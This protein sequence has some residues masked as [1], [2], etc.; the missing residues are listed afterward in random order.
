[1]FKTCFTLFFLYCTACFL[2]I[3]ETYARPSIA[4]EWMDYY[5]DSNSDDNIKKATGTTCQLCHASSDG[6]NSYNPYGWK[7]KGLGALDNPTKA[8]KMTEDF[9]SDKDSKVQSNLKEIKNGSQPGWRKSSKN[10]I[11]SDGGEVSYSS[12]PDGLTNPD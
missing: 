11:Y 2:F 8:F 3:N 6:G 10:R 1:M 4:Y 5:P 7:L 9:N 12:P